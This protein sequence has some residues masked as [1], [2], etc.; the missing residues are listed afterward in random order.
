[1][2]KRKEAWKKK[3]LKK[4]DLF[5]R[6]IFFEFLPFFYIATSLVYLF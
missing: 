1:M 6:F 2:K 4:C 3:K 5:F